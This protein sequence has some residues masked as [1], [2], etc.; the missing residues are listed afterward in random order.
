MNTVTLWPSP[1]PLNDTSPLFGARDR[2]GIPAALLDGACVS[3]LLWFAILL[4]VR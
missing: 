1:G 4:V 2:L 3:A